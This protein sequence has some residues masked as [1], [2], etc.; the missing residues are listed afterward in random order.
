MFDKSQE[1][2]YP[3]GAI[4]LSISLLKITEPL[5]RIKLITYAC[6]P[7]FNKQNHDVNTGVKNAV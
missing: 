3:I 4:D 7:N 2:M 6:R 1:N 5:P